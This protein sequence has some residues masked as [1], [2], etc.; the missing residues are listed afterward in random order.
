ME[1]DNFHFNSKNCIL[2]QNILKKRNLENANSD[3]CVSSTDDSTTLLSDPSS[4]FPYQN[5]SDTTHSNFVSSTIPDHS[6]DNDTGKRRKLIRNN[7]MKTGSSDEKGDIEPYLSNVD[8]SND[9]LRSNI[10]N[11]VS[12][13]FPRTF[14]E[15]SSCYA[16]NQE[17]T[18][19][20][21]ALSNW[22]FTRNNDNISSIPHEPDSSTHCFSPSV[23]MPSRLNTTLQKAKGLNNKEE[24]KGTSRKTT[25]VKNSTN[26][27]NGIVKNDNLRFFQ[28]M[29]KTKALGKK[30]KNFAL[31]SARLRIDEMGHVRCALN[32]LS[33][34][35]HKVFFN[36][37]SQVIRSIEEGGTVKIN[38]YNDAFFSNE[39]DSSE[40]E[41]EDCVTMENDM[42][43]ILGAAQFHAYKNS[44]DIMENKNKEL[45]ES[46]YTALNG[47][48][49]SE[50]YFDDNNA[51]VYLSPQ[52]SQ[53]TQEHQRNQHTQSTQSTQGTQTNGHD[54][55]YSQE[56]LNSE[57]RNYHNNSFH[58]STDDSYMQ[59]DVSDTHMLNGVHRGSR[60]PNDPNCV[61]E[62][63]QNTSLNRRRSRRIDFANFHDFANMRRTHAEH[64]YIFGDEDVYGNQPYGIDEQSQMPEMVALT[65]LG[66]QT[67]WNMASAVSYGLAR[68]V[69]SRL[70]SVGVNTMDTDTNEDLNNMENHVEMNGNVEYFC[71]TF[72]Y[73]TNNEQ[74]DD[75][76][77]SNVYPS[78]QNRRNN[79]RNRR[80]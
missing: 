10:H 45:W 64:P 51:N 50:N 16:S 31:H 52:D 61:R 24:M 55:Q 46:K 17:A 1:K 23:E 41:C 9:V 78:H 6:Y 42:S 2:N 8:A 56:F 47:G 12:E 74:R 70:V 14:A 5:I 79:N 40:S 26:G 32:T 29:L 36:V 13:D 76:E 18:C 34:K 75:T 27:Y 69:G 67:P 53:N 4:F 35:K 58:S 60:N 25:R 72:P 57:N 15:T 65:S 37:Q 63:Q 33:K 59:G 49:N 68:D 77:D 28:E 30:C 3:D 43:S 38:V 44:I 73:D 7:E 39:E 48:T 22:N 54:S 19:T 71:P 62:E 20:S 80:S 11:L 66:T 21:T